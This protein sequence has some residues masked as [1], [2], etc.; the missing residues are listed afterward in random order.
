MKVIFYLSMPEINGSSRYRVYKYLPY[1]RKE[2]IEYYI[3]TP[4]SNDFFESFT[5][6]TNSY[7]RK[8]IYYLFFFFK[9]FK[10]V[11]KAYKYDVVV[12]Q[13][14]IFPLGPP[15][16]EK[17]LLL[18]NKKIVYDIDDA[19]FVRPESAPKTILQ[20]I[21]PLDKV[22]FLMK[23][24]KHIIVA[25][26]YIKNYALNYNPNITVI[27]MCVDLERY[28]I[29]TKIKSDFNK[30]T[31][32][33]TGTASAGLFY[34]RDIKNMFKH[35][36][37]E[38]DFKLKII[39]GGADKIV[40]E[41]SFEGLDIE[42]KEWSLE[43]EISDLYTLDIGIVPLVKR[44]FEKGKFPFKALQ[45]MAVGIPVVGTRWGVLEEI[46]TDGVNGFLVDNEE[47]WIDKLG[48]LLKDADLRKKMGENGRKVV[49][50]KFTYDVN[51]PKFI[52][53]LNHVF[54]SSGSKKNGEE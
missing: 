42:K 20:K 5:E 38:H 30:P 44:E 14:Q 24:S 9:R 33:W 19:L 25:N 54:V 40:K 52:D 13:R 18:L 29:N 47:E 15:F 8:F 23:I 11:L 50:E 41:I 21:K 3:S 53:I 31:I 16:L 45:Y 26:D 12:I 28:V 27:P 17:L 35:L 7:I 32:G 51:A 36:K 2:G 48:V 22:S 4:A 49:K 10:D 1:F 37:K 34:L 46:I 6:Q 39:S 43:D